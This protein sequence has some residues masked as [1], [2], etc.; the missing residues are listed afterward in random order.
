MK[1]ILNKPV[2]NDVWEA[3]MGDSI[4]EKASAYDKNG[5]MKHEIDNALGL[6]KQFRAKYPFVENPESI[7]LLEPDDIFK[8]NSDELGEF[9][10]YLEFYLK[11]LGHLTI[12]GNYCLSQN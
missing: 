8:V 12:R 11:P 4:L 3:A 10:R 6:L 9:F 1:I 5:L 7:D 2:D